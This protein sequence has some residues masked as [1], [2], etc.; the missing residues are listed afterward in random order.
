MCYGVRLDGNING[1][2]ILTLVPTACGSRHEFIYF[3][4]HV[5][6]TTTSRFFNTFFLIGNH[7]QH[8]GNHIVI[9][10]MKKLIASLATL[11]V[12]VLTLVI[13]GSA[14]FAQ[15]KMD[16]KMDIKKDQKMDMKMDMKKDHCMMMHGKMH[17]M[18]D[19]KKMQMDK[20]MTL[21]NGTEVM[22][23]GTCK[24]KD[25]TTMKMKNGDMMDMDGNMMKKRKKV[26]MGSMKM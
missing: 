5:F 9:P 3:Y 6:C 10:S 13:L 15:D 1:V 12:A 26:R 2:S 25:G 21:N 17:M 18:K 23:D 4:G 22:T 24:M 11:T 16:P 7:Q 14:V 20:T 8:C 19:G